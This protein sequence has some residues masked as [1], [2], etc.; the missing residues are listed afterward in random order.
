MKVDIVNMENESAG[1]LELDEAVFG[2]E[3][4]EHLFWEVVKWQ[5]ANR[6]SGTHKTRSR[7][8]VA[9][10]GRKPWAQKGTGRAR[11]GSIRSP[12]WVG[13]GIAHGPDNRDHGY[14]ISKKKKRAALRSALSGR[15][16]EGDVRVVESLELPDISTKGAVEMLEKLDATD[17]LVVDTTER[18][19][20]TG[21]VR[22]NE[23]LRLSVRNLPNVKYLA[24]D[25][26]NVEDVLNHDVLVISRDAVAQIQEGLAP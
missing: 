1:E 8:E 14:R 24:A 22:H 23:T 17:A 19:P 10:G 13:G 2:A 5:Q 26:M 16:Q 15:A 3:V 12:I 21:V 9:G 4:R 11:H 6:R 18:D 20:D 25:G 7:S